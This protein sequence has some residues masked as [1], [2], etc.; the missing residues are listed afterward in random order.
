MPVRPAETAAREVAQDAEPEWRSLYSE[1]QR[2]RDALVTRAEKP[3][4]P[5]PLVEGYDNLIDCVRSLA[6]HLDLSERAR[7]VIDGLLDYH[8]DETV[9]RET[10]EGYS[11]RSAR[12]SPRTR[13][14]T[15]P[16]STR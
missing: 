6:E 14:S 5:L 12:P 3:D 10:T 1:L 16:G 13:R 4:L 8:N 11:R 2:D 9:A 7:S 15:A